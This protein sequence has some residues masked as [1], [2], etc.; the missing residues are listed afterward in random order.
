MGRRY[1][2][3]RYRE[4][5]GDELFTGLVE[6]SSVLP[7]WLSV[8]A[9]ILLY[10]FVPLDTSQPEGAFALEQVPRVFIGI[11]LGIALKYIV[12]FALVLGGLTNLFKRGKSA[13]MFKSIS[14]R[15]ARETLRGLSW[16]DFE[17]LVAEY[18]KKEGYQVN[19][20]DAQGADGGVDVRL[21]KGDERY[22]V[23]C[24]H[25]KAWSVSVKVVR[26]LYGVM[27]AEGA[28]GGFVVTTGKF[29]KDA[30]AFASDKQIE[31]LDGKQLERL[32]DGELV[33]EPRQ[34]ENAEQPICPR[35]GNALVKRNGL[36]GEF[37]GCGSFPK[38]RFTKSIG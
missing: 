27:A 7:W 28:T 15:G 17:F 8:G 5:P 29:T 25:Y 1:Y 12:P 10:V 38:C 36:R 31:L 32:L 6:A 37:W 4:T 11:I 24:K 23:Q 16:K 35:C 34:A 30:I 18:F 9:A 2:R 14:S 13:W 22:L 21:R 19:L 3:R 33:R 26:E 20:I